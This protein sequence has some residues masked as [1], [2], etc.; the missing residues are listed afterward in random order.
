MRL[1][2]LLLAITLPLTLLAAC[3]DD[4]DTGADATDASTVTTEAPGTT[5]PSVTTD[6]TETTD[7][8]EGTDADDLTAT[9]EP[10][11]TEPATLVFDAG[12]DGT[13]VEVAVGDRFDVV[14][15]SCPSCG[16]SWQDAGGPYE[17]VLE[18]T[19][20]EDRGRE[21]ESADGEVMV[22]GYTDH[23]VHVEVVGAGSV[24]F[25][26]GY[27]PPGRTIDDAED[28]YTLQVVAS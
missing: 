2:R 15:E 4:D 8:T 26:L 3:G 16:Y 25:E 22:G 24:T 17:G 23:V 28:R 5:A 9:T 20:E 10:G 27:V 1:L 13:T 6:A 11:G 12:D 19:S 21:E 14:L 7:T 18:I